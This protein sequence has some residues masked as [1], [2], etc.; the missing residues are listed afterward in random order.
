MKEYKRKKDKPEVTNPKLKKRDTCRGGKPHD[1]VLTLPFGYEHIEGLY[2]DARP[3]Y[4]AFKALDAMYKTL[5]E[6]LEKVGIRKTKT[7]YLGR[8]YTKTKEYVCSICGKKH[9]SDL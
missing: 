9:W 6:E 4:E 2:V 3:V 8:G 7:F 5:H 1:W